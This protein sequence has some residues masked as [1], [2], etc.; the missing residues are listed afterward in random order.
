MRLI[1]PSSIPRYFSFRPSALTSPRNYAAITFG[2]LLRAIKE[3]PLNLDGVPE[4]NLDAAAFLKD[5]FYA[6]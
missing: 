5:H 2:T 1:I 3:N 6:M 4:K